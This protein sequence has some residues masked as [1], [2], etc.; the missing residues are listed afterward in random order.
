MSKPLV[1]IITPVYN[2]EKYLDQYF[3]SVVNQTYHNIELIL[4]DDAS[5]DQSKNIIDKWMQKLEDRFV[6]FIYI[7]RIENRGLIYN[8][9]EGISL[10]KGKY[11]NVFASDDVMLPNNI[12]TKVTY[13]EENTDYAMVYSDAYC[14]S[15]LEGKNYKMSKYH[16]QLKGE[17]FTELINQGNFIPAP[18]A[19][20][21]RKV[22]KDLGG[23]STKYMFDDYP[24]W[25]EIAFRYK[26]GLIKEPLVFYRLSPNSLSRGLDNYKNMI[27]SQIQLYQNIKDKYGADVE[28]ALERTYRDASSFLLSQDRESYKTYRNKIKQKNSKTLICDILYYLRVTP[29]IIEIAKKIKNPKMQ[30]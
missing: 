28:M 5:P 14:G 24:M 18:T 7:P 4:I 25:L 19:F 6:N 8:C 16:T 13:L 1:T 2:H 26:I 3:N 20:V 21:R 17:I 22:I 9:N 11:I 29:R 12:E 10:A 15:N 30:Y 27:D 23:Y